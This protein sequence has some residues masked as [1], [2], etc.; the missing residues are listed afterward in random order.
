M[1]KDRQPDWQDTN[2]ALFGSDV[3]YKIK[4]AASKTEPQWTNAGTEIGLLIWRIE[5]F[6]VKSWPKGKYGEFHTGDSYIILHT[7]QPNPSSPALAWDVSF[8]IG[9]ESTQDEYGT[10]AYKTVELD[11]FLGRKATQHREV[12]GAESKRFLRYF[13][14]GIKYL[15]GG[16]ASGFKHVE[17]EVREPVL[18]RLKGRGNHVTLTQVE[19]RRD[20]MNSGDVFILDCE[21]GST[22]GTAPR[23]TATRRPRPRR[24]VRRCESSGNIQFVCYEEGSPR[25]LDPKLSPFAKHLPVDKSVSGGRSAGVRAAEAAGDDA[26]VKGFVRSAFALSLTTPGEIGIEPLAWQTAALAASDGRGRARRLGV[27]ALSMGGAAA[28]FPMRVSAFIFA[29]TYLKRHNRRRCAALSLR[30]GARERQALAKF[31]CPSGLSHRR[32]ARSRS[33]CTR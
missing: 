10:A 13:P 32:K 23:A 7:Y 11:D 14:R 16:V 31:F 20:A 1:Q 21:E 5:Q 22:N 24:S 26:A 12:Q 25:T 29:Q 3:E 15:K 4:E 19:T 33:V 8:W 28:A 2:L 27:R 6:V 18:L 9:M 17:A 30:R